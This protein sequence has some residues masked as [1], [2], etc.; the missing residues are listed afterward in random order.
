MRIF[1]ANTIEYPNEGFVKG[2]GRSSTGRVESRSLNLAERGRKHWQRFH[3]MDLTPDSLAEWEREIPSFGCEC[4]ARYK[5]IKSDNPPRFEDPH[6]W[7]WEI[8]NSVN[9]HLG[10]PAVSLA[11]AKAMWLSVAPRTSPRLV[12]TVAVG[13]AFRQLLQVT[14]PSMEQYAKRCNADFLA[15]TNKR[16]SHWHLEKF[17][18]GPL[19]EQY[20][21]TLFLDADCIVRET[22]PDLFA[23]YPDCIAMHDDLPHQTNLSWAAPEHRSVLE[24]QGLQYVDTKR[25]LNTGVILVG[26]DVSLW[27]KPTKPLPSS[28]C[29]EQWWIDH[30]AGEAVRLLPT[31]FNTQFWMNDFESR[32][33]TAHIVH[34]ASCLNKLQTAKQILGGSKVR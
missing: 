6:K 19:A 28:H 17:R 18:A 15:I 11:D 14:R 3:S 1:V 2:D 30:Q 13:Q 21:Q 26:K 12:V 16:E 8:H 25:I 20:D 10:Y 9:K 34:L 22:C 23:M 33:S 29:A 27:N 32:L 5:A 24:S 4:E 31:E 7:R